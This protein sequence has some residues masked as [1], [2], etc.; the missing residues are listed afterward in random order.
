MKEMVEKKEDIIEPA[1]A[2]GEQ[3]IDF[4]TYE[5][6]GSFDSSHYFRYNAD[7]YKPEIERTVQI[8][9][10]ENRRMSEFMSKF[11]YTNVISIRAKQIENKSPIFVNVE[12]K[13][14]I[15]PIDIAKQE[16]K[17]KKCPLSILRHYNPFMAEIWDVN[18]MEINF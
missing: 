18:E 9:L 12:E 5:G 1:I 3:V 6:R 4:R 11:E 10:P 15:S 17:E 2:E 14:E 7:R 16:I 8:I 13:Y